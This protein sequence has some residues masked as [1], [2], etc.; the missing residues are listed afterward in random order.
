[1]LLPKNKGSSKSKD[2]SSIFQT[3]KQLKFS[4]PVS[5]AEQTNKSIKKRVEI[6]SQ[7]YSA[8]EENATKISSELIKFINKK[9]L[10]KSDYWYHVVIKGLLIRPNSYTSIL[11]ILSQLH[12][13][14]SN[15]KALFNNNDMNPYYGQLLFRFNIISGMDLQSH[16]SINPRSVPEYDQMCMKY[17]PMSLEFAM[18]TNNITDYKTIIEQQNIPFTYKINISDN[19]SIIYV[20]NN[21]SIY[22]NQ[23]CAFYG[24]LHCYKFARMNGSNSPDLTYAVTC[25]NQYLINIAQPEKQ[26]NAH[27]LFTA[28]VKF[29]RPNAFGYLMDVY[30]LDPKEQCQLTDTIRS[31][32]ERFF[33][34]YAEG[35]LE[36]IQ[37][38][39][40]PN[41]IKGSLLSAIENDAIDV[42]DVIIQNQLDSHL[43]YNALNMVCMNGKIEMVEL[44]LDN[45]IGPN[46][47]KAVS[48]TNIGLYNSLYQLNYYFCYF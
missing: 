17:A 31:F 16:F 44:F 12:S 5:N 15:S 40:I 39:N 30:Q 36:Q 19:D 10:G 8:N 2:S 35:A 37:A 24:S 1:M 23:F 32:N 38:N 20:K 13:V 48:F 34:Y 4:F 3:T 18:K 14:F 43:P 21:Q 27:N 47:E 42:L 46:L 26:L 29:H 6:I 33:Y 45:G 7:I 41:N 25:G 9:C 22:Q 28:T 11:T